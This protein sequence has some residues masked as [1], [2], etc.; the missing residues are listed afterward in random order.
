MQL[1]LLS[2]LIYSHN[3]LRSADMTSCQT[4]F[5]ALT[6]WLLQMGDFEIRISQAS[7]RNPMVVIGTNRS[8]DENIADMSLELLYSDHPPTRSDADR[9]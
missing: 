2:V 4:C 3:L 7:L 1:C 9:G 6:S 8:V 5:A